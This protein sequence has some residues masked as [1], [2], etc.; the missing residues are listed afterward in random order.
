MEGRGKG[1]KGK[2]KTVIGASSS[3]KKTTNA[4]H[5][6]KKGGVDRGKT[7][8]VTIGSKTAAVPQNAPGDGLS[9]HRVKDKL[10]NQVKPKRGIMATAKAM[11]KKKTMKQ[12]QAKTLKAQTKAAK[13]P[14]KSNVVSL[15]GLTTK[16]KKR[17][18]NV[19]AATSKVDASALPTMILLTEGPTS[20]QDKMDMR[21]SQSSTKKMVGLVP[22]G[23]VASAV[24][25]S[26][27]RKMPKHAQVSKTVTRITAAT[28]KAETEVTL[29]KTGVNK[30][31]VQDV[32]YTDS[33][34]RSLK[35]E[36]QVVEEKTTEV[37]HETNFSGL[38][39]YN[40]AADAAINEPDQLELDEVAKKLATN[41]QV[42]HVGKHD[43]DMSQSDRLSSD[44]LLAT[45]KATA[46]TDLTWSTSPSTSTILDISVLDSPASTESVGI[47]PRPAGSQGNAAFQANKTLSTSIDTCTTCFESSS[48]A[49]KS[50]VQ[51]GHKRQRSFHQ[52]R[53][54]SAI[55][56]VQPPTKRFAPE[57]K[58][59]SQQSRLQLCIDEPK[60]LQDQPSTSSKNQAVSQPER[61]EA[62]VQDTHVWGR[63][64]NII[65]TERLTCTEHAASRS[66]QTG[67]HDERD[68]GHPAALSMQVLAP[69]QLASECKPSM[70]ASTTSSDNLWGSD[71]QFKS[72]AESK[73]GA[74]EAFPKTRGDISSPSTKGSALGILTDSHAFVE[75]MM[76]SDM[77]LNKEER[78]SSL[79]QSVQ[80]SDSLPVRPQN[81]WGASFGMVP[82][83]SSSFSNAQILSTTPLSSWFLS[84]GCANFLK[85]VYFFET[86]SSSSERRVSFSRSVSNSNGASTD[87]T[88]SRK[89]TFLESLT[90][91]TFWRTWYG[92]ADVQNLIDPPL[93][94]VPGTVR[95]SFASLPA[96][97]EATTEP[98]PLASAKNSN[99]LEG[100]EA[101]IRCGVIFVG[102]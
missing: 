64:D 31:V 42:P 24:A 34:T 54:D 95:K 92:S 5:N 15:T 26:S 78:P 81:A 48:V 30:P 93:A 3:H 22:A 29:R 8:V 43:T 96:L 80:L 66:S 89:N 55:D 37:L 2:K 21:V 71:K 25:A 38:T 100:L 27:T 83:A 75:K 45:E 88:N 84:K 33:T 13:G 61:T 74:T 65:A 60:H 41:E 6:G 28:E 79:A 99:G 4:H 85:R 20:D 59:S 102:Y 49:K 70:Q 50:N 98:C 53:K 57:S 17:N 18:A 97:P 12:E 82:P 32:V 73:T 1:K 44:K 76:N 52:E 51:G 19:H 40:E 35:D 39:G 63:T 69:P 87:E 56:S 23:A 46:K 86:A 90:K 94:F 62:K 11:K 77:E 9:T 7:Q 72:L 58:D 101:D 16:R 68:L 67:R 10:R 91:S 47:A 14:L 36:P